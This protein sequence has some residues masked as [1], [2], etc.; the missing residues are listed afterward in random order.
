MIASVVRVPW[1]T[2]HGGYDRLLDHLPEVQRITPPTHPVARPASRVAHRL[3]ASRCP[4][5]FYPAE[6]F[7]TDLRVL[8]SRRPAH[9]L[10]GDEQFWFSR[11][12]RAPTAVTYHQPPERLARLLLPEEWRRLAPRGRH[13]IVLDP[14]QRNFFADLLPPERVHLVPHGIDT[15]VFTP[16]A[17]PPWPGRPLVLTVGWWLRD[18]DT[19]DAVHH[20]LHQRHGRDVELAVVTREAAAR[21]WHPA[22]RV[23]E[24]IS[25]QELIDLYRRASLLLLPLTGASAN[26][27][28]LEALSCGT[29]AVVTGIGGIPYYAGTNLA[30]LL[31]PPGDAP[32]AATAVD[33]LLGE[34]GTQAH[35]L[36]RSAARGRAESLAWPLV[37]DQV[38]AVYRLLEEE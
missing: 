27:A 35:E 8:A 33:T 21:H 14:G 20:I 10:Y 2:A 19:L 23:L 3:L 5:P 22:V 17:S 16:A 18:F 11:H 12:R 38:R 34:L 31:V 13:L 9:V 32:S 30:A 25:E 36:R 15:T 6:H 28:L 4:L 24:G 26:N 29:P 7:A 37:A 1:H